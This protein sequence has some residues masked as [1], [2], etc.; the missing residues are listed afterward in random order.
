LADKLSADKLVLGELSADN[1]SADDLSADKLPLCPFDI[2]GGNPTIASYNTTVANF[3][4][5][6]DSL[7]CFGNKHILFYFE[8]RIRL[9]QR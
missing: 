2:L 9:I 8:K 5:A 3:Y 6:M 1:L 4:N 7:A